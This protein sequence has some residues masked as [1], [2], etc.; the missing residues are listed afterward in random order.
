MKKYIILFILVMVTA[1]VYAGDFIHPLDF[2]G[3]QAEKD[4]VISYIQENVKKTY[5]SIGM[6]DATTLRMME[7]DEL[8]NFK[9]LTQITDRALLDRTIKKYCD[10]G[11]CTYSTII[12]MYNE[13]TYP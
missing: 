7:K 13:E 8:E 6:G 9:K 2:K 5:S 1:N 3:T 10:I 4:A 12:M 11:M